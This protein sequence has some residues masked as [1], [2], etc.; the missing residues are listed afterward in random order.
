MSRIGGLLLL[1]ACCRSPS[2][3]HLIDVLDAAKH[4]VAP[5]TTGAILRVADAQKSE[6]KF[7]RASNSDADGDDKKSAVIDDDAAAR[8]PFSDNE[9]LEADASK[10]KW[11]KVGLAAWGKRR[12]NKA[13]WEKRDEFDDD[14]KQDWMQRDQT[15]WNE[16]HREASAGKRRWSANNGMR[17]WGK[18]SRPYADGRP[19]RS[20]AD[21]D[22]RVA[23]VPYLVDYVQRRRS[24]AKRQL[25]NTAGRYGGPKRTWEF[26]TMKT[27]GKRGA[28]WP[29][30]V[31]LLDRRM[32]PKRAWSS[33]N[34]LRVWG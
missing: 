6:N 3:A 21:N 2:N 14:Q 28:D 20:V 27:W 25:R 12:W 32:W 13:A 16:R 15:A 11:G 26:N 4:P 7:A 33:D 18:R 10:R 24:P 34:S 22:G 31:E 19:K 1:L 29:D 23:L 5:T 9:Y 17:A 30:H 8:Q